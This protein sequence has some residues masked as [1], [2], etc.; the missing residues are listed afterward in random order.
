[1]YEEHFDWSRRVPV[2]NKKIM[3]KHIIF[4]ACFVFEDIGQV[5]IQVRAYKLHTTV[6]RG[7]H[8]LSDT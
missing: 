2:H 8:G 5:L 4:L 1:M 6:E 3:A 7:A